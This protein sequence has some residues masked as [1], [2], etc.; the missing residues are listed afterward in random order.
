M[1]RT[2]LG[3]ARLMFEWTV[4]IKGYAV[5]HN[6]E[7]A[8]LKISEDSIVDWVEQNQ[9]AHAIGG[10]EDACT[11]TT[12]TG[13]GLYGL[14][15]A[16]APA[17]NPSASSMTTASQQGS[18]VDVYIIDT[19]I[20]TTHSDFGGRATHAFD[21]TGQ[22]SGDGNGH[23]THCAGTAGG[24][25]YGFATRSNLF[26]VKVLNSA[27][28][29]SFACV[30]SGIE[31]V[32]AQN[33]NRVGS[34]SL[35]GGFSAAVNNAVDGAVRSGAAMSSA[36]GNSNTNAC[37][38]SP[39]SAPLGVCVNSHDINDHDP[40]FPTSEPALT[41]SPPEPTFSLPG[42]DQ[43]LTLAPSLVPPWRVLMSPVSWPRPGPPSLL[44]LEPI[45]RPSSFATVSPTK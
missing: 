43:T 36:S 19:G 20:R 8:L 4:T 45:S 12:R 6:D 15:R 7:N 9:V 27:G 1:Q 38:F 35:G 41:S 32:G 34:L 26:A 37:N 18:G 11:E 23:G 39:A 25:A 10:E 42:S 21:C 2:M 28:S 17:R 40:A 14:R 24:N 31:F 5:A 29:G 3:G 22:G 16:S 33:G 30:I 13:N 44:F